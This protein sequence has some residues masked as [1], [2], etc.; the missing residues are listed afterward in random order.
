MHYIRRL[1]NPT[2]IKAF[3]YT[4]DFGGLGTYDSSAYVEI[5]GDLPLSYTIENP[6]LVTSTMNS[7]PNPIAT[8]LSPVG[9]VIGS[10][11]LLGK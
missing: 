7:A 11:G 2:V 6:S 8:T 4:M 1:D 10:T 3:G 9:T 5:E